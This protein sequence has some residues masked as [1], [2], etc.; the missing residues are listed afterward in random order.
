MKSTSH[1]G[2]D[3]QPP[4]LPNR[5]PFVILSATPC[6]PEQSRR[7]SFP[8]SPH[9]PLCH[10]ERSIAKPK[11]LIASSVPLREISS[12]SLRV[13][14]FV[15]LFF[16]CSDTPDPQPA[17][18]LVTVS[19]ECV[20]NV[21]LYTPDGLCLQS[22]IWDCQETKVLSFTT[23]YEGVLTLKAEYKAK[24]ASLEITT[25]PGKTTEASLIF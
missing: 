18:I 19:N 20:C 1:C 15:F 16:S 10:S 21:F 25:H 11:N 6:H 17:K 4:I 23:F 13:L 24:S 5:P 3:P 14:F 2:L 9:S 22:K 12:V 7:I 8:I